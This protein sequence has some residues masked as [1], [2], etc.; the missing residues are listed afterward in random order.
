LHI[1]L[2][3]EILPILFALFPNV[4][5]IVSSHSP[6]LSMGLAEFAPDRA[7]IIDLETFGIS[8]DPTTNELYA[9]VYRMMI[10]ENDRFKELYRS[11][12]EKIKSGTLPLVITEGKTDVQ[13]LR[14]AK[15]RLAIQGCDVEFF[16]ITGDWGDSKL[17]LL[18]EQLSKV[19]QS[20]KIIGIFDRDVANIVAE[21][22]KDGSSYKTYGNNVFAFCLPVPAGREHYTNISIEFFYKDSDLNPC[23]THENKPPI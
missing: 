18:L 10:G 20:R 12:E 16:D 21:I 22:E 3:K 14:S 5:F 9:E 7:K 15:T 8:K 19:A 2:Q 11:L 23:L 17:K 13:H 6:F 1:K 4:Q